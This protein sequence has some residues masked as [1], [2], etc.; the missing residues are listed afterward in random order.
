LD[1]THATDR[2]QQVNIEGLN[3]FFNYKAVMYKAGSVCKA[4]K[5]DGTLI[6]SDTDAKVV[7]QAAINNITAS[8]GKGKLVIKDGVYTINTQ[9]TM[10]SNIE[11]WG[12][13]RDNTILKSAS[14][15]LDTQCKNSDGTGGNVK[16]S[17]LQIL[18]STILMFR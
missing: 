13:S 4:S 3:P 14:S 1:G 6:S 10:P 5:D 17:H 15:I 7:L 8:G 16:T 11:I 12:E 18:Q 2:L 9:W